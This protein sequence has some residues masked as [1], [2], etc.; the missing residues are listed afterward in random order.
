M[1]WVQHKSNS[2]RDPTLKRAMDRW[3]HAGYACFWIL[4][5]LMAENHNTKSVGKLLISW[6][7]VQQEFNKRRTF[8]QL[9]LDFLQGENKL[10]WEDRGE[11]IWVYMP[12]FIKYSDRYTK[13]KLRES[14]SSD[15]EN[16]VQSMAAYK[17]KKDIPL[18]NPIETTND[19]LLRSL[20]TRIIKKWNFRKGRR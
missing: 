7:Q 4:I 11:N 6:K 1:K 19:G 8:V 9:Y 2:R 5:E 16:S 10:L 18:N 20:G 14:L 3:Q 13:Q 12:N 17:R 15:S